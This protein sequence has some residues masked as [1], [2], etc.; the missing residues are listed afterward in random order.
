MSIVTERKTYDKVLQQI[1]AGRRALIKVKDKGFCNLCIIY[2]SI[3]SCFVIFGVK[4][5]V[6]SRLSRSMLLRLAGSGA[7]QP[8]SEWQLT[9]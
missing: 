1:R 2:S 5:F 4:K 9:I 3:H 7:I 6:L 8:P